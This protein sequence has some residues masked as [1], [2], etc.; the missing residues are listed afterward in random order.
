M[1]VAVGSGGAACSG[2]VRPFFGA[3]RGACSPG[4]GNGGGSGPS[5]SR[6]LR[7]VVE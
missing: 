4:S 2:E 7:W 3:I 6:W 5:H 1:L